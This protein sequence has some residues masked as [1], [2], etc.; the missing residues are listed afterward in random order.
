MAQI[1]KDTTLRKAILQA[2]ITGQLISTVVE[3]VETTG[4]E[5]LPLAAAGKPSSATPSAGRWTSSA[6]RRRGNRPW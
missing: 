3:P 5:S 6:D 1:K 4:G 2:A